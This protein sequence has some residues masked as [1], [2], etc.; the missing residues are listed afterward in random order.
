MVKV[1]TPPLKL[2]RNVWA[3][4]VIVIAEA[5][6]VGVGVGVAPGAGGVAVATG[7]AGPRWSSAP[8]TNIGSVVALSMTAA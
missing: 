6:C 4:S 5:G 2:Q 3:V 7:P 8:L 1:L